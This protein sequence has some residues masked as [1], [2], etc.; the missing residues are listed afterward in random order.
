MRSYNI[1][2]D[3]LPVPVRLGGNNLVE[4]WRKKWYE[5]RKGGDSNYDYEKRKI[6]MAIKKPFIIMNIGLPSGFE[7]FH[8]EF[9]TLERDQ[10]F[11]EDLRD[12]VKKR[13]LIENRNRKIKLKH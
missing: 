10:K 6:E 13:L 9:L 4:K 7:G 8:K 3:V 5:F 11:I 12:L 2:N 1:F